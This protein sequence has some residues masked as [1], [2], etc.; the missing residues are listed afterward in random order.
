MP[1]PLEARLAA[2]KEAIVT[3]G[4]GR[5]FLVHRAPWPHDVMTAAHCLPFLPAAHPASFTH[6]R[7]YANLLGPRRATPTLS[8]ECVFVDSIADVAVLSSPDGQVLCDESEAYEHFM[9]GRPALRLGWLREPSE[10]WLLTLDDEWE[11]C[12]VAPGTWGWS[13][14]LIDAI[15][16]IVPGTSGSPIVTPDGRVVGLMSVGDETMTNEGVRSHR[17]RYFQ[18][19]LREVLP[20]RFIRPRRR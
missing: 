20:A 4:E 13:I 19:M 6:E 3:V 7:T 9:D 8:A 2:A 10:A 15:K 12:T 11:R 1:K 5:G 18:P 16:G 17:E 14:T